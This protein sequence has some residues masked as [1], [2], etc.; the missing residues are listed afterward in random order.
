MT[1]V[2]LFGLA[3]MPPTAVP[4]PATLTDPLVFALVAYIAAVPGA[5]A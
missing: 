5:L 4:R 1:W 3:V 2:S